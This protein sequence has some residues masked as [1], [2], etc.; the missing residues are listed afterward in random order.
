MPGFKRSKTFQ[1]LFWH[2]QPRRPRHQGHI[3]RQLFLAFKATSIPFSWRSSLRFARLQIFQN[4]RK[5]LLARLTP[6]AKAPRPHQ[7]L[8]LGLQRDINSFSLAFKPAVCQAANLPKPSKS[9]WHLTPQAKAKATQGSNA[10]KPSKSSFGTPAPAGQGTKARSK[11]FFLDFKVTLVALYWRSSLPFARLQTLQNPPQ[12]LLA[13]LTLQAN[14]P[15]PHQ[16]LFLGLQRDI[17]TFLLEFKPAVCQ[18]S[19]APKPSKRSFGTSDPAGQG[20]K[21]TSTDSFSSPSKRHQYLFPGV[22]ACGLPGF[23]LSKTLKSPF[24]TPNPAGQGTKAT[25]PAFSW[26]SKRL[27]TFQNPPKATLARLTPQANA[28]RPHQ[29]LF[30][31][32]QGDINT[33][34]LAF[35][36][37]VCHASNFPKP[38]KSLFGTPDPAG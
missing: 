22:Q 4:L 38:S 37:G 12:A 18:A 29:Q 6:Q 26:P 9:F 30:L 25:S 19:N 1:K 7:Q 32:L 20:T 31:G 21:A 33:F 15:R 16:Q 8:F 27:Q 34:L 5:A 10:A 28:P 11:A 24:G 36:P 17:N 3:N 14:A 13:P 2:L 23:K 35:K